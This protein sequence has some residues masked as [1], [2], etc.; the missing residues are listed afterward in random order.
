MGVG[1]HESPQTGLRWNNTNH[2]QTSTLKRNLYRTT[3]QY[4]L[5]LSEVYFLSSAALIAQ[6]QEWDGAASAPSSGNWLWRALLCCGTR[7]AARAQGWSPA[8]WPAFPRLLWGRLREILRSAS[9]KMGIG[10]EC[11]PASLL[12]VRLASIWGYHMGSSGQD[13]NL[14]VCGQLGRKYPT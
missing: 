6:H 5:G 9:P 11:W 13:S 10:F 12:I 2:V 4:V 1:I 14:R 8:A 3:I 7:E